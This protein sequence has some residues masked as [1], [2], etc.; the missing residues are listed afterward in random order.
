MKKKTEQIPNVPDGFCMVGGI[1]YPKAQWEE[2]TIA[3]LNGKPLPRPARKEAFT[4]RNTR[5]DVI[6]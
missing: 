5:T 2:A 3:W 4:N 6:T 1:V